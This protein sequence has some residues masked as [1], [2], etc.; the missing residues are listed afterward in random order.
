MTQSEP[1]DIYL[2]YLY[3]NLK[4]YCNQLCSKAKSNYYSTKLNN[5][6]QNPKEGW[7]VINNLISN[8]CNSIIISTDFTN[9]NLCIGNTPVDN[10][11]EFSIANAFCNYFYNSINDLIINNKQVK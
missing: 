1:N 2:T 7:A 11:S 10:S 5:I 6:K 3:N 9:M 4:N 8:K